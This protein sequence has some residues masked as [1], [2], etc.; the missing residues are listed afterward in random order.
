MINCDVAL[1]LS[2]LASLQRDLSKPDDAKAHLRE[3]LQLVD[4]LAEQVPDDRKVHVTRATVMNNLVSPRRG[5][6]A[7]GRTSRPAPPPPSDP[8]HPHTR[9]LPN[10]E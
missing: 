3:A 2:A 5:A 6:C 1:S 9:L 4:T 10:R 8:T 7:G